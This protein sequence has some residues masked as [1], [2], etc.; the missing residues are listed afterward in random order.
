MSKRWMRMG[1]LSLL[2][3][4][5]AAM[6]AGCTTASTDEGIAGTYPSKQIEYVVPFS[7][8]GGVDLVA[9]AVSEYVSK[10]W[11]QPVV[12]VNK[13]GGG[14]AI[15]AEY[16][17]KQSKKDGYTVLADNVSSTSM[18][19]GGMA[20][21]PVKIADRVLMSR[22]ILDP[23]AFAVKADA[24]WKDFQE[25]SEWVKE[26]PDQLTWTSVGPSGTSAFAVA[27]W[28]N[29]IGVD[30]S[31][32]RMIATKGAS[33][34]IPQVAGGHAVL[35]AHTVAEMYPMAQ[36][37]KIRIL[38]VVAPKRSSF[39]PDV[40][41]LEEQGIKGVSVKWWTGVTVPA[42]TPQYVVEKWEQTLEKMVNDP[43][44]VEKAKGLHMEVSYQNSQD[45]TE[46]VKGEAGYYTK[47]ATER[48][49]RK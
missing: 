16:V 39:L 9:R 43:A 42:G 5:L 29:A 25:F 3:V 28:L 27:D 33:D 22:V 15:G 35:A 32:T 12:V 19:E 10:E 24:P 6:A 2:S 31:K 46:F 40:P 26:N 8:G 1:L 49:M 17:L 13:P 38:G 47:L 20:K 41:T 23:V 4:S 30:Y 37:G 45:F 34:S 44:F 21:P 36:A 11:N 18:M 14:G 48:G 7:P